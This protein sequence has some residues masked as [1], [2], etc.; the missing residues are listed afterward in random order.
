MDFLDNPNFAD[1]ALL[2]ELAEMFNGREDAVNFVVAYGNYIEIIDDLVDEVKDKDRV[3]KVGEQAALVFNLPYWKKWGH[4]LYY[5]E[6]IIHNTYFDSVCWEESEEEW[7]R[8]DA[9]CLSHCGYNMLFAI[10]LV[11]FGEKKLQELSLR[12]REHAHKRHIND[13]I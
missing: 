11:E 13:P 2:A 6:R 1:K 10:I 12:F 8:R 3:R 5:V 9:K 7:K 4:A